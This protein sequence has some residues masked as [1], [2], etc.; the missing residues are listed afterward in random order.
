[1]TQAM[2]RSFTS[3]EISP[4]LR[5]RADLVKYTTGLALCENFFV[6]AQG[7][8]YNRPGL[9]FIGEAKAS[10]S[11]M[12]LIPFSFNTEQ[13]YVLV[14][15]NNNIQIIRNGAFL[16]H[17]STARVELTT[18]YTEAQLFDIQVTQSADVLTIT[19]PSHPPANLSRV[20]EVLWTLA[21]INY[22]S[23]VPAPTITSVAAIG[24]GAGTHSKTY[25]YVVTA[26][27]DAGVES[28]PSAESNITTPSLSVTAAVRIT[29]G[30]ITGADY[31]RIY[32]DNTN[33]SGVYGWIG[34]SKNATFDDF[35]FAPVTSDAPPQNRN[36]FNSANNYPG[37]VGFYQQRQIFANTNNEPQTLFT[38]RTNEF[39]SLRTSS[40]LRDG[41]AITL[42]ITSG[43][44]NEIRHIVP[45]DQLLLLTSGGE[46][47]VTEDA[48][49]VLTP[50]AGVRI[51]SY[52]GAS[53]VTPAVINNTVIYLQEK[54]ARIRDLNYQF[55]DD[56]YV[57][58]DLSIMSEHLFENHQIIDMAYADE[59]YGIL[60]CVR[61]DGVML[62][63][64]YLREHQVWGWHQHKTEG[65]FESVTVI[66]EDGR[67]AL[68]VGV[69]RVIGGETKRY[70]ERLEKRNSIDSAD[71]FY[72]DSG[73]SYMGAPAT[74]ISGLGHL[75]GK[76][77]TVL[78]DGNEIPQ[79]VVTSG[80]IILPRASSKV[81]IGLP[82]TAA[83]ET[84]DID[85]GQMVD[86]VRVK[87]VSVSRVDLVVEQSRGGHVG[88]VPVFNQPASV[89]QE[90]K[91]RFDS[92]GYNNIQ[93][94]TFT[95]EVSIQ[96]M[97]SKS[98]GIR[99]EQ[100]SPL[101]LAILAATVDF[102]V[103]S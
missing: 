66:S 94:K 15:Q 59:P 55:S 101:P 98:G 5:A 80:T 45:V 93:L 26:V 58:N 100:R 25:R 37:T 11:K 17:P 33:G 54:G 46:W 18:N 69:S 21:N 31:Y 28:L 103:G 53:K 38:T 19:H 88:P 23:A 20:S 22:A 83:I 57:G 44:I 27:N 13:T 3:G 43:Q 99:I 75:E 73:L 96:P 72:V 63:L 7:G 1:M 36:P 35:N 24:A 56:G 92:D 34:D 74:T 90:I 68:Y 52:N 39:N 6:R 85:L 97:W 71:A 12:R 77:V 48:D 49:G 30:D 40:P 10:T 89:L 41:D 14:F 91:P 16:V 29:Y 62:G 67:D 2:Q 70:I 87:N 61:D 42:T 78:A 86:P 60:W 4:S 47:R 65:K 64:T 9:R 51:Q 8:V 50:S 95:E 32:K 82:Y 81:H 79:Q 76:T 84:L 102:Q